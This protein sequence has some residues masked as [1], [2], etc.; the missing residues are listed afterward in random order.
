[1]VEDMVVEHCSP[2]L[3]GM[4]CGCIFRVD[5]EQNA[6]REEI[7]RT[8]TELAGK[9]VRIMTMEVQIARTL[10]YVYR[11]K[12]IAE[13]LSDERNSSFLAERGYDVS[14]ADTA[15]ASLEQSI[16]S[17]GRMPHEIGLFIGYP[18]EDVWGFIENAGRCFKCVG[19]WKVYGDEEKASKMFCEFRGCREAYRSMYRTGVSIASLTMIA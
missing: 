19:C 8:E 2:T 16:V 17:S 10:V 7:C 14:S 6:V 4:K 9:G 1:M 3:A 11:P 5:S 15:V 18:F 13:M 12:M